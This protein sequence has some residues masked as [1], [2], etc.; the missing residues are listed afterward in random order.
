MAEVTALTHKLNLERKM[1]KNGPFFKR[2][3]EFLSQQISTVT[4]FHLLQHLGFGKK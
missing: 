1:C 2:K 4:K 3:M